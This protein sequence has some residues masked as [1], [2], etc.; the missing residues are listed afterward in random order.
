MRL[1]KLFNRSDRRVPGRTDD[2]AADLAKVDELV[3]ADRLVEAVDL[4]AEVNRRGRRP[5]LETRLVDLRA[6]AA[7]SFEPGGGRPDWPPAY[8]D[9]FPDVSGAVPEVPASRL[10][11]EVLGGAVAHH[12]A[13]IVRGVF[14]PEQVERT[15]EAIERT[16]QRRDPES[17]STTVDTDGA[18]WF[19]PFPAKEG[20][21]VET[22]RR[23]VARQ[24]GTFL[25]DSPA[26]TAQILDELE[27]VGVTQAISGHLGERPFFS[28]QKS[29]LRRSLP[30]FRLVAW[31]QDGSFLDDDVR[32]M[33]IWVALSACGG[34]HP[35][36]GLE[37]VPRRIEEI[38]P[39][40]G[41]M[42]PHSISYDLVDEIAAE[43]PT[44][45]PE[46]T[47]GDAMIFDEHFLHRTHL[48]EQMDY[49]RYAL[50]CWFF[51]PSHRATD[52][53]PLLV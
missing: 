28:L 9:P 49:I 34:D 44:V 23:M 33:N 29:T 16:H 20:V 7:S 43:T 41:V 30:E 22:L 38:L 27:G 48:L 32:T 19:R 3:A 47:P 17:G 51:A 18:A 42:S 2:A 37:V 26:S 10:T 36:P 46:F 35:T 5:D 50:E 4:L 14:S 25:A 8:D 21:K 15:V 39:V 45:V 12:G 40:D 52:Y 11:S 24:G 6:R 53:T 13:L 31:H 1:P